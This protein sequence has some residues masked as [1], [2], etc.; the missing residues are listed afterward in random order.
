MNDEN[1]KP[2]SYFFYNTNN[3]TPLPIVDKMALET[4]NRMI[5]ISSISAI[6]ILRNN[7]ITFDQRKEKRL[8]IEFEKSINTGPH[9]V[10]RKLCRSRYLHLRYC[11]DM[12]GLK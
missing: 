3:M 11:C 8:L 2:E 4:F 12:F 7:D 5:N 9:V 10:Q 6:V 1:S